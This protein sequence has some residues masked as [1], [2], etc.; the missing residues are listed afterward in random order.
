M[1]KL[2]IEQTHSL[3]ADE[4]RRR[5]DTLSERLSQKY[6]IDARW[7]SDTEASVKGSGASGTIQMQPGKVVVSVD[8]SFVLSPVKG[9]V[10]TRIRDELL[11]ALS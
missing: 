11:R 7:T 10:E 5:L 6:G 2:T 4:V 3:A 8:L 1:P 9:K